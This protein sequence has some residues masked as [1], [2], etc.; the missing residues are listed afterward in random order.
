MS[1]NNI[2]F[3]YIKDVH[4]NKCQALTITRLTHSPFT[5]EIARIRRYTILSTI[6]KCQGVQHTISA[7]IKRHLSQGTPVSLTSEEH[8]GHL[9]FLLQLSLPLLPLSLLQVA[10]PLLLLLALQHDAQRLLLRPVHRRPRADQRPQALQ[11]AAEPLLR[12][13]VRGDAWRR[14]ERRKCNE[15]RFRETLTLPDRCYL[16]LV[17]QH[18]I[19]GHS[20]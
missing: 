10:L 1:E 11:P 12:V 7:H 2:C 5:T 6:F 13:S 14:G 17:F 18:Y 4:R 19:T 9:P 15:V 20:I 8:D 3:W 16:C